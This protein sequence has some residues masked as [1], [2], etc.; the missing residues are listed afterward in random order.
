MADLYRD[1]GRNDEALKLREEMLTLSRQVNGPEHRRTFRAMN[2]LAEAY[3]ETGRFDAELKL[4]EETLTLSRKV[5]G[6]KDSSAGG[7]LQGLAWM[8]ATCPNA[9]VRNP[10]RAVELATQAAELRP[11]DAVCVGTLGTAQYRAGENATAIPVLQKALS[12]AKKDQRN[13]ASAILGFFLAMARWHAGDRGEARKEYGHAVA[14]MEKEKGKSR[15]TDKEML[16][17]REEAALLI[18]PGD[19]AK[20]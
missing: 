5:S 8:L 4:R 2:S 15:S 6:L 9:A 16:R 19:S 11:E 14:W 1:T 12:L 18:V 3:S 17:I 7:A 10:K 13:D 20:K